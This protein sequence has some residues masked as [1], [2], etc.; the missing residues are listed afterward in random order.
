MLSKLLAGAILAAV[1]VPVLLGARDLQ[2]ETLNAWESYVKTA[3]ARLQDRVD[4]AQPF[5]WMDESSDRRLRVRR[6][7]VVI[8]PMVNH[9][10]QTVP[11]GLIHH[12]IGALFIPNVTV[13]ALESL[14]HDYDGYREIYKPTVVD[15]KALGCTSTDRE[16]SMTWQ[17]HVLF[18]TAAIRGQYWSRDVMLDSGAA[19][20]SPARRACRKLKITA[21]A[22][23]GCCLPIQA[24]AS[25]GVFTASPDMKSAREE[26]I[27][28]WRRSR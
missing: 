13:E 19:M 17:R 26:F 20:K 14:V 24:A 8:A 3:N 2:S 28:S 10:T 7:E 5:L 6:G 4:G 15:S 16:F 12:W 22:S 27:S 11:N 9:G 25:S 1:S 23:N 18:V 21:A